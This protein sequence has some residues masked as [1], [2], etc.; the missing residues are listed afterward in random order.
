MDNIHADAG[1]GDTN[2][3]GLPQ[4]NKYIGIEWAAVRWVSL[5]E[6]CPSTTV[7]NRG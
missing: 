4:Q 6:K 2:K 7:E 3:T 5:E 1:T